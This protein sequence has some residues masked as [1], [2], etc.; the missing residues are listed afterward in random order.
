MEATKPKEVEKSRERGRREV[1]EGGKRAPET[2]N[3]TSEA[4]EASSFPLAAVI[5]RRAM[6]FPLHYDFSFYES[7]VVVAVILYFCCC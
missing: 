3:Q 5:V 2:A 6:M 4:L 1:D 7:V